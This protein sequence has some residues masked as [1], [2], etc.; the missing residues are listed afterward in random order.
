MAGFCHSG[1]KYNAIYE[2]TEM[3]GIALS[4]REEIKARSSNSVFSEHLTDCRTDETR[5]AAFGLHTRDICKNY[6]F[7]V[8]CLPDLTHAIRCIYF[9]FDNTFK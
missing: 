8:A 5:A 1:D 9:N 4:E 7:S 2:L 6:R 3:H